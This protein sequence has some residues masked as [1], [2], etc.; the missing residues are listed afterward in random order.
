MGPWVSSQLFFK[1][2]P[3]SPQGRHLETSYAFSVFCR[4]GL[5]WLWIL[6]TV[7]TMKL[8]CKTWEQFSDSVCSKTASSPQQLVLGDSP[9]TSPRFRVCSCTDKEIFKYFYLLSFFSLMSWRKEELLCTSQSCQSSKMFCRSKVWIVH[10]C[11]LD[12][13]WRTQSLQLFSWT[14]W[15]H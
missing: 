4:L 8:D 14:S 15:W 3:I 11:P 7:V 2:K 1:A 5:C 10:I 13:N 6:V 12:F 9:S